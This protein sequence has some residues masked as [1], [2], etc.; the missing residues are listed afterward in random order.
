MNYRWRAEWV[1]IR[2]RSAATPSSAQVATTAGPQ[3]FVGYD[4]EM[5]ERW[6]SVMLVAGG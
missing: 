4:R 2:K 1:A 6:R 5:S 3:P